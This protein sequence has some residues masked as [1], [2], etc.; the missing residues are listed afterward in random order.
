M[1]RLLPLLF[2]FL[3][4]QASA[5]SPVGLEQCRAWAHE[6]S[7]QLKVARETLVQAEER[8][9]EAFGGILPK[10]AFDLNDVW[11]DPTGVDK[12]AA[13][14]FGG[15]VSKN[16]RDS[17]FSLKQPLFSGLREWSAFQGFRRD[18]AK[19][20]FLLARS[21]EELDGS[22]ASA[23][24]SV[25]TAESD[26][27][28]AVSGLKLA[29]DRVKELK[30]FL[31]LGKARDSELFTAQAHASA[32]RA[33]LRGLEARIVLARS[34]LSFITGQDLS[35]ASLSDAAAQPAA[36]E[37]LAA[38]LQ[39]AVARP[40]LRAQRED[41][42]GRR[43][44]VRFEKGAHWPSIDATGTYYTERPVYL[45]EIHWDVALALHLPIFEGGQASS[46]VRAAESAERQSA[47]VLQEMERR[48]AESVRNAHAQLSAAIE[49]ASALADAA[50]DAE[51]SYRSLQEEYRLG[52]TTNLEVLQ[53]MDLL[54]A[55]RSARDAARL[56][57][58][59]SVF[60]F[61]SA[62]GDPW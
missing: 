61:K 32:L 25:V 9:R 56:S 26:R 7:E 41:L 55:Q 47:F 38:A 58:K 31:D 12:L 11:Q 15:F 40:D 28:N 60:A 49:Q 33:G 53:A 29:E 50:A 24:Y 17:K 18:Q 16:Q 14:G 8:K 34:D 46:R 37:P 27:D 13:Q 6:R 62:V 57:A 45:K 59:Q 39:R 5:Q 44:Q 48:V 10:V 42:A 23:F 51:K 2:L 19:A 22:V 21:S 35:A 52:L 4:T 20:E 3:Q 1:A 54:E 36:A 30:G 43:L